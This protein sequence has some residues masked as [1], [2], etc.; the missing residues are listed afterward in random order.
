MSYYNVTRV[1]RDARHLLKWAP[2]VVF[3]N[4]NYSGESNFFQQYFKNFYNSKNTQ[5]GK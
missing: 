3:K 1:F 2:L 5:D 4:T